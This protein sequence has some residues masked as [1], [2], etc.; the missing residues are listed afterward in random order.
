MT[1]VLNVGSFDL[2]H[3]GHLFVFSQLRALAGPF[4]VVAVGLND[5]DFIEQFKGHPPV[6]TYAEREAVLRGIRDI[7]TVCRNTGGADSKPLIEYIK[8]EIIGVG[9]DWWSVD[10]SRYC[11]QMGFTKE[12]L[13]ERG[14]TL[15]YL[16]W[17]DG[18]SSTNLRAAARAMTR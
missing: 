3:P 14:I 1:V 12:W 15:S 9:W 18:H 13:T 4:G 11:K 7:D 8:P 5:D 6:Q 17:M 10:D 2:L 16:R